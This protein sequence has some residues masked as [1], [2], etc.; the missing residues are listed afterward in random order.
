MTDSTAAIEMIEMREAIEAE[1]AAM[2]EIRAGALRID[3]ADLQKEEVHI[4]TAEI[5]AEA[6]AM[7]E[8]GVMK[9]I[10]TA[11]EAEIRIEAEKK[12]GIGDPT[13]IDKDQIQE[14]DSRKKDR[15]RKMGMTMIGID[16]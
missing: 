14:I 5:I 8:T 15:D 6:A 13:K 12:A 9:V 16:E 10:E 2:I 7:T 4:E 11:I 3:R 1:I